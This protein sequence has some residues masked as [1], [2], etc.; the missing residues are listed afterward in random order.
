MSD[1]SSVKAAAKEI[2]EH[3]QKWMENDLLYII[4]H[5]SSKSHSDIADDLG[6]TQHNVYYLARK[7]GLKKHGGVPKKARYTLEAP[8][9]L[10]YEARIKA[11]SHNMDL[12]QFII[13][14]IADKLNM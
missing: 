1:I 4:E 10:I 9:R 3:S 12:D 2:A 5:Y 11:A 6:L 13:S 14:A 7:L 8:G